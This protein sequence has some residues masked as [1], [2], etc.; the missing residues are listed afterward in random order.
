MDFIVEFVTEKS[1]SPSV[2]FVLIIIIGG[3]FTLL[4]SLLT[5]LITTLILGIIKS[6]FLEL[7]Q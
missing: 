4:R 6:R 2:R 7:V 3:I 5:L 1:L